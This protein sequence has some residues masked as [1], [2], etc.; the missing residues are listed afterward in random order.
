MSEPFLGEI[1]IVGFNFA[2]VGWALCNGQILDISENAALFSLLGT[3]YGGN[4]TE[5][6]AL[7]NLQSRVPVHMGTGPGLSTYE[8]GEEGGVE[9]V[10]QVVAH[11]HG[12]YANSGLATTDAPAGAVPAAGG[13]YAASG[14]TTLAA[15]ESTGFPDVSVIQPFLTVNF[16]IALTGI[17]PS[18]G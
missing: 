18:R 2:P 8:M 6:F 13:S 14:N 10:S 16:I 7:P 1:R 3:T 5:N 11:S 17:F 9:T 12:L 4:G 15:T